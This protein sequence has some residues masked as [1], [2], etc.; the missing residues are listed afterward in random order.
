MIHRTRFLATLFACYCFGLLNTGILNTAY[1]QQKNTNEKQ[2]TT[3]STIY[4][5]VTDIINSAGYTYAEIDTGEKKVWA[6][7]PVTPLKNGDMVAF[8]TKMPMKNFHSKSM[9]RDFPIIYFVDHFITD[10]ETSLNDSAATA[11]AHNQG[12]NSSPAKIIKT[13]EKAKNGHTIA[14][15]YSDKINLGDK[16]IR[17]RGQVT[18]FT[19]N[20]LGKNW[21]HIRDNSTTNDLTITTG[22]TAAI[23]DVIIIEGKLGLNKDFGYGY[24]Y[25]LIIENANIK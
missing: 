14:E 1:A 25:P 4:G 19:P 8:P 12:K 18:K 5:K 21:L 15:I 9:Q 7:G 17:V 24:I 11:S 10:K 23:D 20:I 13:I 2:Q 22:N 3:A 6:A 16:T